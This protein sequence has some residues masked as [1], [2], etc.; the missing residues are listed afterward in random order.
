MNANARRR[1][2]GTW[3]AKLRQAKGMTFQQAA[4][5]LEC[6]DS[7]IRHWEAGRSAPKKDDL[8]RL[9]DLYDA[10]DDV[11]DLLQQTRS[12]VSKQGWWDS[13]RLP[14]W[15]GPYVSFETTA[16][17]ARNF[18]VALVPG[19]LQTKEYAYE[20][21]R[22]GRYVTDPRDIHKRVDARLERQRR[23]TEEPR[24][25]FR[26]V[27][28]EEALHRQVGGHE[29][30]RAQIEHLIE[31]SHLPNVILQVLP[32]TAGAHASPAGGFAVLSFESPH[33]PDVGFSDTPLGGHVIDDADD[34]A[35]LRYL[36]DELRALSLSAPDTVT[37]LHRISAQQEH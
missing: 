10:P 34:V 19:L 9:L 20:I 26:A 1:Q 24:L 23:L 27:I 35:A 15:F 29:V 7:R 37:L 17:E 6:S 14:E 13:Y 33:H 28:A 12:D 21:H 8:A 5:A 11:R 30:M 22:A 16:T 32:L 18:E 25:Q 31:L 36:F 4:D 3:L 2:V